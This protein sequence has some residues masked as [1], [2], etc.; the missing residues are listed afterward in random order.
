MNEED[1]GER[2]SRSKTEGTGIPSFDVCRL[3][4]RRNVLLTR[5]GRHAVGREMEKR[6]GEMTSVS[7]RGN[8]EAKW[9]GQGERE[10][11][12][13]EVGMVPSG[14]VT[15]PVD[16]KGHPSRKNDKEK[17]GARGGPER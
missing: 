8:D 7:A 3:F 16:R 1:Q 17:D 9:G 2:E 15:A 13:L 5:S 12:T 10:A 11:N 6:R 14:R 4:D